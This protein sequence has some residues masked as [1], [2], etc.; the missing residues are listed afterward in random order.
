MQEYHSGPR[1]AAKVLLLEAGLK[2]QSL[3]INPEDAELLASRRFTTEELARIFNVPPPLVGIWDHA[4]FTISETATRW[5]V[6]HTL[7]PWITKLQAEAKR[8]L[9]SAA[10]APT[11]E[12]EIDTSALLRGD[13]ELRWKSHAIAVQNGILTRDEI[14]ETEGWPPLPEGDQASVDA[15]SAPLP[16]GKATDMSVTTIVQ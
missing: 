5:Y 11:H 10:A 4:S 16:N 14:R 3:T 8:S 12:L 2:W 15:T 1:N 13:P 7:A 6:T 9:F